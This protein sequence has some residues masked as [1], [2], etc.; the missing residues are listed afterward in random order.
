M[1]SPYRDRGYN[2]ELVGMARRVRG[3]DEGEGGFPLPDRAGLA[4]VEAA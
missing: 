2:P 1:G 3:S 4:P